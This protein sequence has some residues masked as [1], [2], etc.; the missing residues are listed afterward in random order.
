MSDANTFTHPDD[1]RYPRDPHHQASHSDQLHDDH[2]HD[3]HVGHVVPIWL[4]AGVLGILLFLT[5]VTVAVTKVDLGYTYNLAIALAIAVV[6]AGFVALYFMHLRWDSP[7][8]ALA[9]VASLVFLT[10]FIGITLMDTDQYAPTIEAEGMA[11]VGAAPA[12]QPGSGP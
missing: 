10:L 11:Q 12:A 5:V 3:G 2:S 8:N 4:L 9:F 6:K 1:T 7:F